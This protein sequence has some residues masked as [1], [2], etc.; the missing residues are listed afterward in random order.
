MADIETIRPWEGR[1]LLDRDGGRIGIIDA[2]SST[3]GRLR[4]AGMRPAAPGEDR[5]PRDQ[6]RM[7][8]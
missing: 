2:I 1:T 7:T 6:R 3:T 4:P 5:T 8:P